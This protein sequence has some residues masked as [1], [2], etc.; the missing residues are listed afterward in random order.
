MQLPSR[1]HTCLKQHA[2]YL[3]ISQ[4]ISTASLIKP[5]EYLAP[6]HMLPAA[7]CVLLLSIV[8]LTAAKTSPHDLLSAE[9]AKCSRTCTGRHS[10][11]QPIFSSMDVLNSVWQT[12]ACCGIEVP[13]VVMPWALSMCFKCFRALKEWNDHPVIGRR[14]AFES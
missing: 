12:Q 8:I 14:L 2:C 9:Q 11:I 7:T 5:H 13:Y 10:R 6:R 1:D 3:Q 4:E